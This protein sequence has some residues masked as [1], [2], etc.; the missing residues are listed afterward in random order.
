MSAKMDVDPADG[1]HKV[2]DIV[3]CYHGPLIYG[4]CRRWP[5]NSLIVSNLWMIVAGTFM[6]QHNLERKSPQRRRRTGTSIAKVKLLRR[7]A[8]II[9]FIIKDGKT[10]GCTSL[11]H[12]P[13]ALSHSI[14]DSRWDEWVP[15]TRVMKITET[16]QK[17]QKQ[18]MDTVN[19]K[20][21]KEETKKKDAA[22]SGTD[23]GKKR[24]RDT[25]E[26][27]EDFKNRPEIKIPIPDILKLQLVDDWERV[28]K[29]RQVV[30]LP[31]N[32]TVTQVLEQY[33]E[34]KVANKPAASAAGSSNGTAASRESRSDDVL[35]EVLDGIKLYFDR[36]LGNVLLYRFERAQYQD[37]LAKS[38]GKEM[39]DVY[40]AEH[41]L[42]LFVQMPSFIAHTNMDTDATNLLRQYLEDILK[43]MAKNNKK[44]FLTEYDNV[45][46]EYET[47]SMPTYKLN[48]KSYRKVILHATK[49]P[50]STNV[51]GLLIGK[52]SGSGESQ[53]TDILD[54]IPLFHTNVNL[55][56]MLEIA[57]SQAEQYAVSIGLQIVGY[58]HANLTDKAPSVV[59]T[60]I[61]STLDQVLNS[62][63]LL[64]MVDPSK[65]G[66]KSTDHA[67]VPYTRDGTA[68]KGAFDRFS[69]AEAFPAAFEIASNRSHIEGL[70]DFDEHLDNLKLD[71]LS[72][73]AV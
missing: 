34:F 8:L 55:T 56:P 4:K 15:E 1:G 38:Q 12:F 69:V 54:A 63:V 20:K 24:P 43:W 9:L 62:N 36:S 25:G 50:Y 65:L 26:N 60:K 10:R 6:G 29:N 32:P 31:R 21:K 66:A 51:N 61:A 59:A 17:L 45:L 46:P 11:R 3:L 27:D 41:L 2:G 72:N 47:T 48:S 49:F 68:W 70:H 37:L 64:L 28:T 35:N 57:V 40:G 16:S 52:K 19:S 73:P 13:P 44:L 58:Y 14:S 71:W 42:R 67:V 22:D 53:H 39:S 5:G 30:T 23:R 33:R 18:L 7:E